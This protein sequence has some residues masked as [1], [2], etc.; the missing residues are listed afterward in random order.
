M[1]AAEDC[2][3]EGSEFQDEN[4][5]HECDP[6]Y[7]PDHSES[8]VKYKV[9]VDM[10]QPSGEWI[11][12]KGKIAN[13]SIAWKHFKVDSEDENLIKCDYCP[14]I[15]RWKGRPRNL[16]RHLRSAHKIE[17]DKESNSDDFCQES[18]EGGNEEGMLE[19]GLKVESQETDGIESQQGSRGFKCGRSEVWQHFHLSDDKT[20]TT[21][22]H[23]HKIMAHCG[24]TTQ[25]W[26]HLKN[27]HPAELDVSTTKTD[28]P[29]G[30]DFNPESKA[31]SWHRESLEDSLKVELQ[32]PMENENVA[33]QQGLTSAREKKSGRSEVWEHFH[34]SEDKTYTSC[35]HCQKEFTYCGSTSKMLEHLRNKHPAELD[36]AEYFNQ[37]SEA[38]YWRQEAYGTKNVESQQVRHNR[39]EVWQHFH[40]SEDKTYASCYHCQNEL[41]YRGS[42]SNMLIHLRNNH[43]AVLD[44]SASKTDHN[45]V[46]AGLKVESQET[47]GNE[48]VESEQGSILQSDEPISD[49]NGDIGV[50]LGGRKRSAIWEYFV[51]IDKFTV[52][53]NTCNNEVRSSDTTTCL[54]SHLLH[55]H[56]EVHAEY[57]E[58]R[59]RELRQHFQVCVGM[60][61]NF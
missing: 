32:K 14:T 24:T 8:E 58:K 56:K 51:R 57:K 54:R 12:R 29:V 52:R 2:D 42:T 36:K 20:Y 26:R 13:R 46:G 3:Y 5:E 50:G 21:C 55:N 31:E 4:M 16:L 48:N 33:P 41:T 1:F 27:R 49:K 38:D 30:E 47:N 28:P 11:R 39:S 44:K 25:M 22:Y 34:L 40:L 7:R 60:S 53:C 19:G 9:K 17:P 61:L 10:V 37:K 35:Y 15:F 18:M 59:L 43:P 6:D 45:I 23:C